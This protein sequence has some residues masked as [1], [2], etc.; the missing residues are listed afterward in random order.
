MTIKS[1]KDI[2]AVLEW[3]LHSESAAETMMQDDI[4]DC[5]IIVK[6]ELTKKETEDE[7]TLH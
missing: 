5:I 3:A 1:L 2:L 4:R 7:Q 6:L